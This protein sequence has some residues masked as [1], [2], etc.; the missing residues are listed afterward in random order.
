MLL[1][2]SELLAVAGFNG[3]RGFQPLSFGLGKRTRRFTAFARYAGNFLRL[4]GRI[5]IRIGNLGIQ[6][7]YQLCEP[8]HLLFDFG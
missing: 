4:S 6:A 5:P 7:V 1:L 8:S 3:L 2:L